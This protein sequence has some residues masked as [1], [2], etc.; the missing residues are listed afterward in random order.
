MSRP[1]S[2]W[3]ENTESSDGLG[4]EGQALASWTELSKAPQQPCV[5][6]TLVTSARARRQR[7]GMERKSQ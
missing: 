3:P 2:W 7:P 5:A 1:R 6:R 4:K